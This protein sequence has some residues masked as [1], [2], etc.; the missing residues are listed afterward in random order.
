ML[1]TRPA[2]PYLATQVTSSSP[3]E[4]VVLLY[5]GA[6]RAVRSARDAVVQKNIPARREALSRALS[7]IAELQG[8]LDHEKAADLSRE[9]DRIYAWCASRLLDGAMQHQVAPFEEVDRVLDT[10]RSAWRTIA[11]G[12]A[13]PGAP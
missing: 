1:Q 2:N 10:L 6:I 12:P 13:P 11:S 7:I 5:D 4:L 8:T 9:L 3:L